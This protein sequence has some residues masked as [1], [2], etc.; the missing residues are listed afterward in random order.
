MV[1]RFRLGAIVTSGSPDPDGRGHRVRLVPCAVGTFGRFGGVRTL[2]G[3]AQQ[4][5]PGQKGERDTVCGC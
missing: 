5:R 2:T 1:R 3:F 4:V